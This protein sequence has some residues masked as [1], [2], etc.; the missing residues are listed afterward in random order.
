MITIKKFGIAEAGGRLGN[1]LF[2]LNSLIGVSETTGHP[3]VLAGWKYADYFN[4]NIKFGSMP[5]NCISLKESSFHFDMTQFDGLKQGKNYDFTGYLQSEKYFGQQRI[6]FKSPPQHLVNLYLKY[7]GGS[8]EQTVAIHV[9]RGDYVDNPY[10]YQ[11]PY[12]Y[13]FKALEN[14]IPE[15]HKKRILIFS[16]DIEYC[17]EVFPKTSNFVFIAGNTEI[18]DLYLMAQC[19]YH[20]LSNSTFSW[21]G[22]YLSAS[23]KVIYPAQYFAGSG[24]KNDTKDFWPDRWH[25]FDHNE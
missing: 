25:K 5:G 3:Y 22:A 23:R 6:K 11:L 10:Y 7:F 9:R 14:K 2:Q 13:Y 16:D 19:D 21:W 1:A 20:I 15:M 8:E 24:L 12:I 18:E 4:L 17:R